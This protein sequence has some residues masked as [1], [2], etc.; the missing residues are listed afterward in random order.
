MKKRE[1][2]YQSEIAKACNE[3]IPSAFFLIIVKQVERDNSPICKLPRQK[4]QDIVMEW[5]P[6]PFLPPTSSSSSSIFGGYKLP[7]NQLLLL[8]SATILKQ[9][10]FHLLSIICPPHY[11][12]CLTNLLLN[13]Q[14]YFLFLKFFW[15]RG[16]VSICMHLR[17]LNEN[18]GTVDLHTIVVISNNFVLP[19][20]Y[21][22]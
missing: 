22:L 19:T 6:F 1:L 5:I 9:K 2:T 14:I 8:P 13:P 17:S 3:G 4:K 21:L 20:L 15:P 18:Q 11:L 12:S 10:S 16:S 7:R